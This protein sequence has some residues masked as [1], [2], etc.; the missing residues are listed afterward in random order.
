MCSDR[1]LRWLQALYGL[2]CLISVCDPADR[3]LLEQH[4]TAIQA[5]K[6]ASEG[7]LDWFD[8][9]LPAWVRYC[10]RQG[11]V[12]YWHEGSKL[13]LS[14]I[15]MESPDES[16]PLRLDG[17]RAEDL[18]MAARIL[19]TL[20]AENQLDSYDYRTCPGAFLEETVLTFFV[21]FKPSEPVNDLRCDTQVNALWGASLN[22]VTSV[23]M[24]AIPTDLIAIPS[25]NQIKQMRQVLSS[26]LK[27]LRFAKPSSIRNLL[28]EDL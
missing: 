17:R 12:E 9:F 14:S 11:L 6:D 2:D 21:P 15:P 1:L 26:A 27:N 5:N 20:L 8:F 16:I 19:S 18:I 4:R 24:C 7:A 23:R 25:T 28:L 22:V 13:N 3:I 10:W